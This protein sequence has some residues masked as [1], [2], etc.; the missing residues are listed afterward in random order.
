MK[1]VK[2][3]RINYKIIPHGI[4]K[5]TFSKHNFFLKKRLNYYVYQ[6]LINIKIN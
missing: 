5:E 6:K 4:N 1:L 2:F 3:K